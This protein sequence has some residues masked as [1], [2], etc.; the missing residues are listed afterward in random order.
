MTSR[1]EAI[2]VAMADGIP[3]HKGHVAEVLDRAANA[4]Q[5]HYAD[6]CPGN[7]GQR[8][9]MRDLREAKRKADENCITLA[10]ERH[11]LRERLEALEEIRQRVA[12]GWWPQK[13]YGSQPA[14]WIRS[15]YGSVSIEDELASLLWPQKDAIDG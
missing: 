5:V 12:D 4:H 2:K 1:E 10:T 6:Q 14:R 15:G 8:K 7:R 3:I 9:T 13:A 11:A